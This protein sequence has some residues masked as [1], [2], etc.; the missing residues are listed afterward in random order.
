MQQPT[1]RARGR[2]AAL[3]I[4]IIVAA[5]GGVVT[6]GIDA[7]PAAAATSYSDYAVYGENG[8]FI[9]GGSEVV[10]LVGARNNNGPYAGQPANALGMNGGATI[11]GDARIGGNVNMANNT[12]ITGT[13]YRVGTLTQGSQ[14]S[15]GNDMQVADADLP[16]QTLSS[17]S[18]WPGGLGAGCPTNGPNQSF[19]QNN[20]SI[21][22]T[23]GAWGEVKGGGASTL[24][25]NGAG[26]YFV[27]RIQF[28]NGL[29]INATPG[30]RVFVCG[31]VQ[32][33]S[34]S[35][36]PLSLLPGQ[37]PWE[38]AGVG[39]AAGT[40]AFTATAGSRWI[41]NVL[42]PTR[43]IHFG[44]S[45]G[46]T[47]W[48]GYMWGDHV[49][50]EHGV[51]TTKPPKK[52]GVKFED[53]DGNGARDPGDQGLAGWTIYVDYNDNGQPDPGEPS[54]VTGAG[55][56]YQIVD[57][58]PGTWKVREVQQLGWTCTFPATSDQFGCY[59]LETF[60][61]GDNI[62]GNDFG[63]HRVF[64]PPTKSGT[65]FKDLNNNGA[66]DQGEPG[67]G[68]WTIDLLDTSNQVLQQTQTDQ[69]GNYTFFIPAAGTYRV[70]EEQQDGGW[71]QTF[72]NAG[73][74]DPT[75][76]S[77][78]DE[79]PGPAVYGYE[80]QVTSGQVLTG[81]D[82]GNFRPPIK[83]GLK[84]DDLNG[85]GT[86]DQGEPVIAGWPINLFK[87]DGSQVFQPVDS[88]N[89][90][91]D[92]TYS[93]GPLDAGTYRVCEGTGPAGYVQTSP[94]GDTP[95]PANET[96]TDQCA[97]PNIYG[98]EFTVQPGVDLAGNNFGNF[99]KPTKSG[100][101]F[102]DLDGNGMRDAGEPGIADWPIDLYKQGN[103]GF[104][105]EGSTTTDANGAYSFGPLDPGTYRVCE[106]S[107]LGYTQTLPNAATPDPAN[108]TITDQCP[109]PNIYGYEF[110]AKSGV[111]LEHNDFANV[112]VGTKSGVKFDDLNG[113]GARDQGEPVIADWPI[114]L[115]KQGNQGFA[116]EASTTTNANGAYS[117]GPLD[118]GTYRVCEGI[119]PT[120][121]VQT[122]PNAGTPDPTGE[123]ITDQCPAP[124]LYG[125]EFTVESGTA[126]V[127]NNF[128]NFK[129]PTKSGVKFDDVNG[130]GARDQGEPGI[131]GWSI[132]L[133]REDG[134]Q[135]FQVVDTKNTDQ[136]GAYSFG[137]L[138]PGTYRVCEGAMAGWVQT[139]PNAGTSDPTG[140]TIT[141]QCPA[142]N[143]YG[144][145]FT[146]L[147]GANR[148]NNNF[149]NFEKPTKS[150]LK[151][152]DLDGNGVRDEGE[153]VIADW[154]IDLYRLDGSNVFQPFGSTTT[155]QNGAYS[156]GPLDPGTYRVCEGTDDGYQT[157][158]NA[159]TPDPT[160]ETITDECPSPNIHG[161][162]FTALSGANRSKNDF[163]NTR[164][165]PPPPPGPPP[166][167]PPLVPP[168][169]VVPPVEVRGAVVTAQPTTTTR[170][171]FTGASSTWPLSIAG[172]LFVVTGTLAMRVARRRRKRLLP[173]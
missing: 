123:T 105:L 170:T 86:R 14:S 42:V 65:K 87:L 171:A 23:P 99:K 47:T 168:F 38:V 134:N 7:S 93:F 124:N 132:T 139:F 37:F 116:L 133:Y 161:Y 6:S 106:G 149:G 69:N 81:N 129:K 145:Q 35:V 121:Y 74:P 77:I 3:V 13:L 53:V 110:T 40:N 61:N 76:E 98:Y 138:D 117:F 91:Q 167:G 137:P 153:P 20:V 30:A 100:V 82:F 95:D 83:S 157:F 51:V 31:D 144:Y 152:D 163:G 126:L 156:F 166:P 136:N 17:M 96:I 59:H 160:G 67:L 12:T 52:S 41:G 141:D 33:G 84:F 118:L 97:S 1:R 73:T 107:V 8:V 36:A 150:G 80:F 63:N 111:D 148:S 45:A 109:S 102:E 54:A 151:F 9:G 11:T 43:G 164:T 155:D 158:P 21:T 57:I 162:E 32:L 172:T 108:E 48:L 58:T 143:V 27:N 119:G 4:A 75:G 56:F 135:T 115:Y 2:C 128:G 26:D 44:G 19:A 29:T 66:R 68:G 147:S 114:V 122:F 113:N 25:F 34:A 131:E 22:L 28:G 39:I 89:T 78:I 79:C 5:F 10:G 85:N 130:N 49:D 103:Q 94:N 140:E 112:K 15:I 70:C 16:P 88:Q 46:P 62:T 104:A 24:T 18:Q 60:G 90:G 165:P 169:Q 159:G 127:G 120:G 146:A 72:P 101:K 71:V 125:Y 154:P 64:S 92:G 173:F 142:P 55:G 50:I